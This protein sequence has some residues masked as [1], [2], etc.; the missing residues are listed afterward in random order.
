[1]KTDRRR[2]NDRREN[3][4]PVSESEQSMLNLVQNKRFLDLE[5]VPLICNDIAL[6]KKMLEDQKGSLV[7]QDQFWPVKT[8]V[9]GIVSLMLIAIVGALMTLVIQ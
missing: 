4:E 2:K 8:L 3:L 5:R 9:Y 6:I 1:M 7:T